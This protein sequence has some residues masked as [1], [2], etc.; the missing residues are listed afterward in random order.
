[1]FYVKYLA[2]HKVH[3]YA[4]AISKLLYGFTSVQVIIHLLKL[5]DYLPVDTFVLLVYTLQGICML[6]YTCSTFY[7]Y[8]WEIFGLV[9][10]SITWQYIEL[11]I[12]RHWIL[13][14]KLLN[15]D[16]TLFYLQLIFN[17]YTH[18]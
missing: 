12:I 1:M 10:Y 8:R 6:V 16:L 3:M 15:K 18:T 2:M 9:Q 11:K 7:A 5:L 4:G 14:I 13:F 17:L